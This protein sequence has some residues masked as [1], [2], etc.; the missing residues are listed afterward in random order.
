MWSQQGS[1]ELTLGQG[2]AVVVIV[3]VV[4]VD[5]GWVLVVCHVHKTLVSIRRRAFERLSA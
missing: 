5:N 3:V 4:V 2:L 1:Q